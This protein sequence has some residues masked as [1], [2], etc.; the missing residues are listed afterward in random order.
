MHSLP[1]TSELFNKVQ[2]VERHPNLLTPARVEWALR[3]RDGNGLKS[4][5]FESRSGE[6]V[7]HEPGFLQWYLGL[8]GRAKPRA[9]RRPHAARARRG[10]AWAECPPGGK[11]YG[12]DVG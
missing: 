9:P 6:L 10:T 5:V 4:F 7:V 11:G 3:Q 2:L 8:S 1:P 12:P